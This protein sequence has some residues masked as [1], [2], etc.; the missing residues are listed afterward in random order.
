MREADPA[1][2]RCIRATWT[3]LE[4]VRARRGQGDRDDQP[5]RLSPWLTCRSCGRH[6]G[7]PNCDVSLIVHRQRRAPRLPPLRPR[8]AAAARLPGLRLDDALRAAGA[9]TERIEALL[10]ERL[11]PMPVFRLDSDTAAGARRATLEILAASTRRQ[12]RPR[13]HPD[14][15]QGPRLPRGRR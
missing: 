3:A 5:A 6:W 12:R 14:G 13:R 11:A 15:R 1:R 7:C 10:A 9:G 8:R 4:G 2:A